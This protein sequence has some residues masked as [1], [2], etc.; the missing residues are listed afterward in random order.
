MI[1]ATTVLLFIMFASITFAMMKYVDFSAAFPSLSAQT[2]DSTS[3]SSGYG[4][5]LS[6]KE[7]RGS[8]GLNSGSARR[9]KFGSA[10]NKSGGGNRGFELGSNNNN[11]SNSNNSADDDNT[12]DNETDCQDDRDADDNGV[13]TEVARAGQRARVIT[14]AS[15]TANNGVGE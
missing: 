2:S 6:M 11:N 13:G 9:T 10:T 5:C 8:I 12:D 7:P 14:V 3:S 15:A 1:C 4:P